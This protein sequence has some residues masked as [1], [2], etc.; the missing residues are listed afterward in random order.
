M[1][2]VRFNGEGVTVELLKINTKTMHYVP[3]N[4]NYDVPNG[5]YDITIIADNGVTIESVSYID[6]DWQS[7]VFFT[8]TEDR[9]K[10]T[11]TNFNVNKWTDTI[12]TIVTTG[13]SNGGEDEDKDEDKDEDE[14]PSL[15]GF[16]NVYLVDRTILKSIASEDLIRTWG[17]PTSK[18]RVD[19][20]DYIINVME[21]PFSIPSDLIG[22]D[23]P[24]KLGEYE[25]KTTAKEIKQDLLFLDLGTINVPFKYN[26][27]FDFM[28][29]TA[30]LYLP[31]I[32]E[33][34]LDVEYVINQE[35]RIQYI[36]DLFTGDTTVNIESSKTGKN[37]YSKNHKLGRNIPFNA[38][39]NIVV[40]RL[41]D[42]NGLYNE[43]FIPYIEVTRN[44]VNNL[45][46]FNNMVVV[47]N[48]LL[49][50]KGF[51][52]VNEIELKTNASSNEKNTI[53][54]LLKDGV[55]IK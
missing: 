43:I 36:I 34:S 26:N 21:F 25:L 28:D 41:S 38:K 39:N 29:T 7:E 48:V 35:I 10:A 13:S 18:I 12:F 40:N 33:I 51:I 31:F 9:K 2:Y 46:E 42:M 22:N 3:L 49:H 24:I 32:D 16:T 11:K 52:T 30:K 17:E 47:E 19:L 44:K 4:E 54:Q 27:S 53:I 37:I 8:I 6:P 45:N 55:Y 5:D 23:L 20:R 50:E 1:A 15:Q 14:E